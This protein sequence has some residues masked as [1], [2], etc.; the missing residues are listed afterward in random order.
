M[1]KKAL[2]ITAYDRPN[3]FKETLESWSKVRGF[4]DWHV[5][6]RFEPTHFTDEMIQAV[7][8][9]EHPNVQIIR[10][11]RIYGV[12]HHPWVGFNDLFQ[13]YDFVVRGEDDL[14]VSSDILEY[15]EWAAE[16]YRGDK[17]VATVIGY[18]KVDGPE[19][20]VFR[21]ESFSPWVWGTWV[22][23]WESIIRDTWDHDYSTGGGNY[24]GWDWNLD[25]RIF[26]QHGLKAVYPRR[27]RVQNIGR[28]G[29][30]AQWDDFPQA[31]SFELE[32]EPVE[33]VER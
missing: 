13:N 25:L 2:F 15:F 9:L 1:L 22:D 16:E 18:S 32:R 7:E 28:I 29:V 8:A 14:P 10:N 20:E 5:V 6:F 23:R 3:Y 17:E 27:S 11:E 30:H 19:D 33:Y 21:Q 24:A 26:P 31:T 4:Y 12:L